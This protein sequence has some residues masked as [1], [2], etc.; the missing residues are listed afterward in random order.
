MVSDFDKFGIY[1][2]VLV[3]PKRWDHKKVETV[4]IIEIA[5]FPQFFLIFGP[6]QIYVILD[7]ESVGL[8]PSNKSKIIWVELPVS[9]Q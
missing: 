7:P 2:F 5:N 4:K 1:G 8:H 9:L 6:Y 3:R